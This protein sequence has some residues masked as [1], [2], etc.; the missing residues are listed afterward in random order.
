MNDR[1]VDAITADPRYPIGRFQRPAEISATDRAAAVETIATLPSHL[2]AAVSG[3]TDSQ[4]DTPYR[5]GG[6]TV[7]QLIH[8][9]A[10]SHGQAS[11]R[12]RKTLTEE[13]PTIQA[14]N[15]KLWAELPDDKSA[16][17]E[18]SLVLLEGLHSRWSYLL[19]H[20]S[21]DQW[22]R[23]FQHPE[24]GTWTVDAVTQL[25]SWHSRHH[26]AHVTALAKARGW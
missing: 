25:Y 26:V 16:S 23:T 18:C 8:H 6:W 10:D 3:W 17:V 13:N 2:R 24:S 9:I 14:Y 19:H 22:Q 21:E 20:L 5:E 15:E 12:L 1:P 7:R 11:T 4:L